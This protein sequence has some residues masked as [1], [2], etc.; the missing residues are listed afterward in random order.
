M[1]AIVSQVQAMAKGADEGLRKQ[2]LDTLFRLQLSIESP[3]DSM[4]RLLYLNVNLMAVRIGCD[5]D[6]FRLLADSATPLT[7]EQ[8]AEKCGTAPTLMSRLLRYL[9][10]VGFIKE[11]GPDTYT[12]N[13]VCRTLTERGWTSGVYHYFDVCS[14]CFAETPEF[15]KRTG[16]KDINDPTN[17]PF[18][19]AHKSNLPGFVWAA[20]PEN[21]WVLTNSNNFMTVQR[22]G[23]PTWLDE[24]AFLE[25]AK[26]AAP[27]QPLFVD[28]GGGLGHQS[29]ALRKALPADIKNGIVVQDLAPVISQAQ[30]FDG[31]ELTVHNFWEPNPVKGAK[32]YYMRN[33]IH[34]WPDDKAVQ[35]LKHI[36]DAM[37]PDSTCIID[38]MVI[39]E[40]GAHWQAT[41]L[42]M[43]MMT[44]LASQ[45]RTEKQFEKLVAA[46]GL[47]I[48]KIY[49]YTVSLNDCV[50]ECI[51]E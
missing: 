44:A 23:M 13:Q 15:L 2:L 25:V 27:E 29:V 9:A 30:P 8:V 7:A 5:L 37:A 38:E 40:Q 19:V 45:E 49:P 31:V 42:D 20:Q 48:R 3:Q 47:R 33:I 12:A 10:S 1:D 22:Q 6:F 51:A 17:A 34:D 18:N 32:I 46:A 11:A 36:K 50:I 21:S 35:I 43:L 14:P 24:Y 39:P 41:Q 16:Y 4:Q 28:V 26:S